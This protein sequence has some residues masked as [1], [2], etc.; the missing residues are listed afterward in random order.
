MLRKQLAFLLAQQEFIFP[1]TG[2]YLLK[3]KGQNNDEKMLHVIQNTEIKYM[4]NANF[5]NIHNKWIIS[6]FQL[7]NNS[8]TCKIIQIFFLLVL[9]INERLKK[10]HKSK[11]SEQELSGINKICSTQKLNILKTVFCSLY[12][13]NIFCPFTSYVFYKN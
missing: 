6:I 12:V 11:V 3:I 7:H 4:H 13:L 2:S 8:S 9:Q 10:L 5:E 1:D